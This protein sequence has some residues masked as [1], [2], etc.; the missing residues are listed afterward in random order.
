MSFPIPRI[1]WPIVI[2]A[3]VND[4]CAV[5][6]GNNHWT[7]TVP[8]GNYANP[9]ALLSELNTLATTTIATGT[10]S[11]PVPLTDPGLGTSAVFSLSTDGFVTVTLSGFGAPVPFTVSFGSTSAALAGTLGMV[12]GTVDVTTMPWS[13]TG[14][15]QVA[16]FWTPDVAVRSDSRDTSMFAR[17]LVATPGGTTGMS[18]TYGLDL[19]QQYRREV[20]VENVADSK[21]F[22]GNE[23]AGPT[24]IERL[25]QPGGGYSSFQYAPDRA[26]PG[27]FK[28]YSLDEET[29]QSFAPERLYDTRPLYKI[30][31]KML[32]IA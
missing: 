12:T 17:G 11:T 32:R 1:V 29:S 3:T 14:T 24:A 4:T 28:T 9:E 21:I 15:S 25:W 10:G 20:V 5:V 27:T 6:A 31:L 13:Q 26:S 8:A 18:S 7:M 22:I 16:N 23:T 2:V 19:A 30:D